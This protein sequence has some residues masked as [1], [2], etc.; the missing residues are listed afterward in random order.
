M[1]SDRAPPKGWPVT[2]QYLP[3]C[4]YHSSVPPAIRSFIDGAPSRP[5][6]H[7]HTTPARTCAIRAIST[8]S[9]PAH[10]QRGLFALGT[11][12]ARTL[13]VE[14]VGEI[15][16]DARAESDYDLSL[17][18]LADGTSVGVDAQRMGN[19]ARFVNDFRGIRAKP[20][21]EFGERRT[22]AGA[23]RMGVWSLSERIKKGEEIV[24]SYGKAWW[25]TRGLSDARAAA[26][27]S[28][29]LVGAR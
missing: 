25:Q 20:N 9:H 7:L 18:R 12:A 27:A 17:H 14:Y 26:W 8:P 22:A 16:C 23:L 6:G 3:A 28:E 2:L 5:R 21:A 4:V 24:V 19:E 10:G 11:I 29:G 1:P 13:I 15:H